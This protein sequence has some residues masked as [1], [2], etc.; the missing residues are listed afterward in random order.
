VTLPPFFKTW[1][2]KDVQ[3]SRPCPRNW[4]SNFN[5]LLT[6]PIT[7][8]WLYRGTIPT[9]ARGGT[10]S[11][12]QRIT[13]RGVFFLTPTKGPP[14]VLPI[15]IALIISSL[16]LSL[17]FI[18]DRLTHGALSRWLS[19]LPS[20]P[21]PESVISM[22]VVTCFLLPMAEE[23]LFRGFVL[24]SFKEQ[25]PGWQVWLTSLLFALLH[26]IVASATVFAM[27][28]FAGVFVIEYNSILPAFVLHGTLNLSGQL[29]DYLYENSPTWGI[30][31][32]LPMF[33]TGVLI[34]LRYRQEFQ[35]LLTVIRES[36]NDFRREFK[37][38]MALALREWS[39]VVLAIIIVLNIISIFLLA[40]HS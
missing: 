12:T 20:A 2:V 31:A 29:F 6:F 25:G 8:V 37:K 26:P 24:H 10:V 7:T 18:A 33:A 17:E 22:L 9:V 28:I 39:Y 34:I 30:I 1:R 32:C 21:T 40:V 4:A 5:C 27:S 16:V 11:A 38:G 23:L 19:H 14:L 15:A 13:Q 35:R 36:Y 3:N